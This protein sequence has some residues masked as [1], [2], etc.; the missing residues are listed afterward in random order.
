MLPPAHPGA[1]PWVQN[2]RPPG[3]VVGKPC[4]GAAVFPCRSTMHLLFTVPPAARAA[5]VTTVCGL[6]RWDSPGEEAG[7][8]L[9]RASSNL[10]ATLSA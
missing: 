2:P 7:H 1:L 10:T 6:W 3:V 4:A 5:R 8:I 9:C